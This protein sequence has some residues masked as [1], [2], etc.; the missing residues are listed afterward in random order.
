MLSFMS[1]LCVMDTS[2]LT[3]ISLANIV[4][5]S[6]GCPFGL[7]MVQ[8]IYIFLTIMRPKLSNNSGAIGKMITLSSYY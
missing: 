4:S 6:V 1:S 5:H 3:D 7:L 2:L 8:S